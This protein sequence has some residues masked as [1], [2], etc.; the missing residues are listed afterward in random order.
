MGNVRYILFFY[1][2]KNLRFVTIFRLY[3]STYLSAY[4]YV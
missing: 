3:L 1:I 4:L 2:E